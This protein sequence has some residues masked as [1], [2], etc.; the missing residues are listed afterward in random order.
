MRQ[1]ENNSVILF[2]FLETF[3]TFDIKI[4]S[5]EA[6][7]LLLSE[8]KITFGLAIFKL[9]DSTLKGTVED[10]LRC[11]KIYTVHFSYLFIFV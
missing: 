9:A 1:T 6:Y 4:T 2:S 7:V 5:H 11:Y 3:S 8:M 10:T